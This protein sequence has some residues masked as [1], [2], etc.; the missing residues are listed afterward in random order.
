M[1]A[2]VLHETLTADLG[3]LKTQLAE[4][5]AQGAVLITAHE[6]LKAN[7]HATVGAIQYLERLLDPDTPL[8]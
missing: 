4:I 3:R 7:R 2:P 5:D 1:D 8:E 6:Q